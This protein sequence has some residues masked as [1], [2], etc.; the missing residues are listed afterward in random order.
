MVE[1]GEMQIRNGKWFRSSWRAIVARLSFILAMTVMLSLRMSPIPV[2][3]ANDHVTTCASSGAG[4]LPV[5][6]AGAA[7]GDTIVFDQDCSGSNVILLSASI[8]ITK[9]LMIDGTGHT[10]VVDGGNAMRAFI[11]GGGAAINVTLKGLTIQHGNAGA[12]GGGAIETASLVTLYVTNC[13]IDHNAG[14]PGG[15]IYNLGTLLMSNSTVSRNTAS[16]GGGGGIYNFNTLAVT[17]STFGTNVANGGFGGGGIYNFN[18][19]TLTNT[20]LSGN[21]AAVAGG[22]VSTVGATM[23]ATNSLVSGNTDSGGNPDIGGVVTSHGHNLI[24]NATGNGPWLAS[25]LTNVAANLGPLGNN[26][27]TTQ[28]FAPQAGS[29]ATGAGDATV[30]ANSVGNIPVASLDQRGSPRLHS[31][32]DVGA[33]QVQTHLSVIPFGGVAGT[34]VNVSVAVLDEY[35]DF[36]PAYAGKVHFTSSDPLA[37]LPADYTFTGSGGGKDNGS[38]TAVAI[39]RTAGTQ[40]VTATDLQVGSVTGNGNGG[41]TPTI[42]SVS[43][44]SGSTAGGNHVALTGLGFGTTPASVSV[45]IGGT[46]AAVTNVTNTQLTVTAP[47]HAA[48]DVSVAVTVSGQGVTLPNGYT[49]GSVNPLPTPQPTGSPVSAANVL[50]ASRPA[51]AP[52][53]GNVTPL[54]NPRP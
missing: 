45:T 54:P 5:V 24:G 34:L 15:G 12:G 41:I 38:H 31:V 2:S 44:A 14:G 35:N 53:V 27:G 48:G 26:G 52:Q 42:S 11:I 50:P 49:Y 33:Y 4:S 1:R 3:A 28:T 29:P 9:N 40:S 36:V 7:A 37:T 16:A 30:C 10:V 43:P 13:T 8:S 19:L 51:G 39:F 23:N 25:D 22:I 32:C 18:T 6:V 17:N 46:P 20:T 21:S 47:A